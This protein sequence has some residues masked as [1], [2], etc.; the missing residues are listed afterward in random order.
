M[1]HFERGMQHLRNFSSFRYRPYGDK[2][3]TQ[4]PAPRSHPSGDITTDT[5]V[6]SHHSS[7]CGLELRLGHL[8]AVLSR[9]PTLAHLTIQG[10]LTSLQMLFEAP[11]LEMNHEP[12]L[13]AL[14]NLTKLEFYVSEVESFPVW[15]SKIPSLRQLRMDGGAKAWNV[16][17]NKYLYPEVPAELRR[18]TSLHTLYLRF[19]KARKTRNMKARKDA[20]S[21]IRVPK[22]AVTD[23]GLRWLL[24]CPK[25]QQVHL[26]VTREERDKLGKLRQELRSAFGGRSVLYMKI[27]GR[28]M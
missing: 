28:Y 27:I 16:P 18:L 10:E 12:D 24:H 20:S 13:S 6:H 14:K 9:L 3:Q 8:P 15:S 23:I 25:L 4:R 7:G 21:S 2:R 22:M 5:A 17:G 1:N 26:D 11:P 19:N